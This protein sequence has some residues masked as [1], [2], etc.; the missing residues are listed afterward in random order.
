MLQELAGF[1]Q[2]DD[3]TVS[4][5]EFAYQTQFWGREHS[6][7]LCASGVACVLHAEGRNSHLVL[8]LDSR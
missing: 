4:R 3:L 5:P 2:L 7:L 1:G 6:V 8:L